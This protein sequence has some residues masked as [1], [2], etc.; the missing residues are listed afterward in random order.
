MMRQFNKLNVVFLMALVASSA[1]GS[2]IQRDAMGPRDIVNGTLGANVFFTLD[3]TS[4]VVTIYGSGNMNK[5]S[6]NKS[7]LKNYSSSIYTAVIEEGVT[8]IAD[9]LF[10]Q[11]NKLTSVTIPPTVTSIGRSAFSNCDALV[12]IK[13][14]ANVTTIGTSVFH[15]CDKLTSIEV[16]KNNKNYSSVDGVLFNYDRTQ[17]IQ[18]PCA[19][20]DD[21]VIPNGVT[22]IADFAFSECLSSVTIPASVTT[23]GN[24]AINVLRTTVIFLG[25]NPPQCGTFNIFGVG[26]VPFDYSSSKLCNIDVS[27]DKT[28]YEDMRQQ[29]ESCFDLM[30]CGGGNSAYP[31]RKEG[32]STK[33][34]EYY[35]GN[36]NACMTWNKCESSHG[37]GRTCKNNVECEEHITATDK[38]YA[39]EVDLINVKLNNVMNLIEGA[40]AGHNQVTIENEMDE[41]GNLLRVVVFSED[42]ETAQTIS[43]ALKTANVGSRLLLSEEEGHETDEHGNETDGHGSQTDGHGNETDGHG[44]E[45]EGREIE[46][47][48]ESNHQMISMFLLSLIIAL[49]AVMMQ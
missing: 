13:I 47:Y 5:I 17:L 30:V 21:Y 16:D 27:F 8:S 40:V 22:S 4:H 19:G 15:D 43:R 20:D 41:E 37:I 7:P 1:V 31:Q 36:E 14:P 42:K 23:I 9:Y 29:L 34:V 24:S 33:C 10:Q 44:S 11:C 25:K 18:Y 26:C 49:F 35:S 38:H 3:T 12:S 6:Q 2:E 45:T 32:P 28:E 46:V 48:S 39:V